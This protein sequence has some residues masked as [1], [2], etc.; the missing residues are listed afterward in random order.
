MSIKAWPFLVSRNRYLD[1][2]TIVAPDFICDAGIPNWLARAADC[3]FTELGYVISR[4]IE[5]SKVGDFTITFRVI[6][7]LNKDICCENGNVFLKDSFG[8]EIYL[9]EGVVIKEMGKISI[10]NEDFQK[11]HEQVKAN[12]QKFWDCINVPSVE[13]S[14]P[15]YLENNESSITLKV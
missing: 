8:R 3:D 9:I 12:Y 4:K 14:S 6:N 7:A 10:T 5:N 15:F 2:R 11:V 13:A 1:Y